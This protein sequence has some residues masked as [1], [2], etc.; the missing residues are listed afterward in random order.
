MDSHINVW[1]TIQKTWGWIHA[2]IIHVFR[3][4]N[5][6]FYS[7]GLI[8]VIMVELTVN[9]YSYRSR[10]KKY[11]LS[12]PQPV[13]FTV[14]LCAPAPRLASSIVH[15]SKIKNLTTLRDLN[16]LDAIDASISGM[17]SEWKLSTATLM[18]RPVRKQ[19]IYLHKLKK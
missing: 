2:D 11:I 1:E 16:T 5:N 3:H 7:R 4:L 12:N 9:K 18:L 6:L 17:Y 15:S 8:H 14:T 19:E 10:F 13:D